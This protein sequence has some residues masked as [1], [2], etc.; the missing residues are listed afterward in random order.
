MENGI[1]STTC[2]GKVLDLPYAVKYGRYLNKTLELSPSTIKNY[3][4]AL[5]RFWK[6]TL[7]VQ[8]NSDEDFSEYLARYKQELKD[9]IV[10]MDRESDELK[11]MKFPI[12]VLKPK[13]K[14]SIDEDLSRLKV[15]FNWIDDKQINLRLD[16]ETI[17]WNYEKR[18]REV[19]K[20]SG[21]MSN[22]IS[23]VAPILTINAIS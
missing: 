1:V 21:Y 20:H 7:A 18:R 10:I 2:Q 16:K 23:S 15:Y 5:E 17:N 11:S 12:L 8:P 14:V 3:M 9:G 19:S 13:I 4:E 22:N 6:W